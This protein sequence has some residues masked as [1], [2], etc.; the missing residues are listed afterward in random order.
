[1]GRIPEQMKDVV[2]ERL[3]RA[4]ADHFARSGFDG[5]RIDLISTDAGFAKGTVYNYFAS[6][7]EL[8]GAVVEHGAHLAADRFEKSNPGNSVR[9]QL[10]SLAEADV[11]VLRE[12]ESFTRVLVREAMSVQPHTYPIIVEHLAPFILKI[13][14]V[15]RQGIHD[16]EVRRDLLPER[17]ALLFVGMLSLLYVQ[18]WASGGT[19]PSLDEIP[20]L[21]VTAFL[22]G[23][24][25][26]TVRERA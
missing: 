8:F 23:A 24:G 7:A 17:Q 20:E 19:W 11:S 5:A 4:A 18:R 6:K 12:E 1:M 14:Q 3:I 13:C 21:L 25:T 16:G 26:Y 10:I 2:R 9:Q 15:I 22:D